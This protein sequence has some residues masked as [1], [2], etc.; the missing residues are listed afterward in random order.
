MA[1][2]T[3]TQDLTKAEIDAL[4]VDAEKVM[5]QVLKEESAKLSKAKDEASPE[6]PE[7]SASAG[8]DDG[9][10]PVDAAPDASATPAPDAAPAPDDA[11]APDASPAAPADDAAPADAAAAAD[12]AGDAGAPVDPAA[13]KAEYAQLD[14]AALE[15]HYMAAK[16]AVYE[17]L[18]TRGSATASPSAAPPA[19]APSPTPSP[20]PSATPTPAPE[21]MPPMTKSEPNAEI[22]ALKARLEKTESTALRALEL[23]ATPMRKSLTGLDYQPKPGA[24]KTVRKA[25]SMSKAEITAVLTAKSAD[26]KLAKKD[27]ETINQWC[28]GAAEL[29][30]IQHLLETK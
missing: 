30:D 27:R 24:E 20:A 18:Q 3:N 16:E 23:L 1:N 17:R 13:L 10:A 11:P 7:G 29:K 15:M 22:E 19:A 28:L 12:P 2:T 26:S 8:A 25:E 6:T 5:V 21:Q 4:I 9:S 14:D